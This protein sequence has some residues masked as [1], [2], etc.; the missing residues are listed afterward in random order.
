MRKVV[1]FMHVSLDGF[2][3]DS[4]G[5]M[6]WINVDEEM[7]D[8]AG[9]RTNA[10]DT[11]LYGRVTYQLMESYWPTAADQPNPTK[12]DIEHSKWYKS[13]TKVVVSK[14]MKDAGKANTIIIGEDLPGEIR[15]LKNG[16]GKEIIIFGSP[17]LA[18]SLMEENLIDGY[19]LFVNPILIGHG[20]PLFKNIKQN[21]RLK[22]LTN[23]TFAS[24]VVCLN[25]E[26]KQ[27]NNEQD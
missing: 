15:K 18:H 10:S 6:D 19:W 9:E 20:I 12:H 1:L 3:T 2:T 8:Y 16:P 22:L 5:G 11:A 7:F 21:V 26:L 24:G 17:S 25:Y 14:T 23:R 27:K 13:V 4:N